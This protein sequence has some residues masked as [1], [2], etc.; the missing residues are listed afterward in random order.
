MSSSYFVVR[1]RKSSGW[2]EQDFN[3]YEDAMKHFHFELN[4][5]VVKECEFLERTDNIIIHEFTGG[6][7]EK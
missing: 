3:D 2:Q 6:K 4:N 1:W 7:N 5:P